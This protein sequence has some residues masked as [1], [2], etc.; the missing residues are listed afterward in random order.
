VNS[1]QQRTLEAIFH[2]PTKADIPWK[3][4]E[5]LLRGLGAEIRQGRGSRV[6]VMLNDVAAVFHR[7]H[8]QPT[9][10]KGAVESMRE[11]LIRS[12]VQP[13]SPEASK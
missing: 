10:N 5:S 1:K 12:R 8:P 2:E 13:R 6:R 3:D 7:P 11:F 4:I 9:T